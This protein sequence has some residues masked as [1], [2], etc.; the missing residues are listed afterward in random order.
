VRLKTDARSAVQIS[1]QC[2]CICTTWCR[3][4]EQETTESTAPRTQQAPNFYKFNTNKTKNKKLS[5][6]WETARVTTRSVTR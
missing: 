3:S 6:R 5:Y 2:Q 4:V 1:R